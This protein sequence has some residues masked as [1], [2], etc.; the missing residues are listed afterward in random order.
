MATKG[1]VLMSVR[2]PVGDV[3]IA[4][5][6]C[7]I[8]RGVGSL[9]SKIGCNSFMYYLIQNIQTMFNTSNDGGTVFG[10]I[11]KDEL[12]DIQIQMI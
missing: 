12:Y 3:N 5:E 10:S 9:S 11:T 1:D 8:G 2:A 6:D 7:C 4:G